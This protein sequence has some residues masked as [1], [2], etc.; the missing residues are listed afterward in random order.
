MVS[1]KHREKKQTAHDRNFRVI[2]RLFF[3]LEETHMRYK[4]EDL[5]QRILTFIRNFYI[6]R[7]R[8]PSTTEIAQEFGI[9]RSTSQNYLV[10][11][12]RDGMISYQDGKLDV[13]QL[14]KLM[15]D[16]IQVPMVRCHIP[17]WHRCLLLLLYAGSFLFFDYSVAAEVG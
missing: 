15:P 10:A 6:S 13:D 9:A 12:D 4:S 14:G 2:V 5:K 7:D 11:M 17:T 16:R 8:M 3:T 1:C